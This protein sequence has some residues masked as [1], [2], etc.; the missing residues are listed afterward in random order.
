MI[1]YNT[2]SNTAWEAIRCDG[3][4]EISHNTIKDISSNKGIYLGANSDAVIVGNTISN[5][6]YEG[7][8]A[9]AQVVITDNDISGGWHGIQ[10]RNAASGSVIDGNTISTP[11]WIGIQSFVPVDITNNNI[12][13]GWGGIEIMS[14][15]DG[16]TVNGNTVSGT[17]A[18]ALRV[19]AQATITN[20]DFSDGYGGIGIWANGADIDGNNIHD[21]RF[22]G[23]DI[24][25]G[26]T[27]ATITNNQLT[28]NPYTGVM[29]WGSGTGE[30]ILINYNQIFGNGI[31][32]VE[33]QRT[34][35]DTKPVDATFNWWGDV[36]GPYHPSSWYYFAVEITNPDGSG[37]EVSDYVLYMPWLGMGGFVTGGGTIW[38]EAGNYRR[39]VDAEGQASFGFV[40]KYKKGNN[41]PDGNTNFVFEAGDLHFHSSSYDWLVVT[42]SDY[43][44]F[45]GTGSINGSGEY[46][47]MLWAGDGGKGGDDTF[48][49]KI[50]EEDE[51]GL[52]DVVYDNSNN[53]T[54][55][56]IDSGSI[57]I[58]T[59]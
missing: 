55:Q 47:F 37:D 50:W 52:E 20:N 38:S 49:I 36:S 31:F 16:S 48:R 27:S 14:G 46:K 17:T 51:F 57:I 40:S 22:R 24:F 43:A 10:L 23:V 6:F 25:S 45:K 34:D 41:V 1:E 19:F 4:A 53:S 18:E 15:A 2:F 58:H 29:V 3:N 35:D 8:Q 32:G 13:G 7:I 39:D 9:W 28:N 33:S 5:T 44:K 59:K 56:V 30:G 26:V 11:S 21:N 12:N 42:G 54:D